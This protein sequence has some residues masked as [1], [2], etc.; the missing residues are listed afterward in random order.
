MRICGSGGTTRGEDRTIERLAPRL[1]ERM[2]GNDRMNDLKLQDLSLPRS[3]LC[4]LELAST[5]Q[6]FLK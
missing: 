1:E 2:N 5:P 4:A 6:G 3:A